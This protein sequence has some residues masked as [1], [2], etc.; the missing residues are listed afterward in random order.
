MKNFDLNE[1]LAEHL[2]DEGRR[3]RYAQ[4]SL[5]VDVAIELNKALEASGR[6][7]KELAAR[8]GRTEGFISQVLSGGG[9]LTL[10]TLGDFAWGLDCAL[11]VT[12]QPIAGLRLGSR[13]AETW[14]SPQLEPTS[15]AITHTQLALAA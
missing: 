2:S 1:H 5:I 8:L 7:Q 14:K 6:T 4:N 12:L 15:V 11:E 10:R 3:R 13:L 9:N